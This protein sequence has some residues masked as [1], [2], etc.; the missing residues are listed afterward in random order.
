MRL[1]AVT[2][3][4][5][6]ALRPRMVGDDQVVVPL[7]PERA[8]LV[9]VEVA[10]LVLRRA[11]GEIMDQQKKVFSWK[12][13]GAGLRFFLPPLPDGDYVAEIRT[14]SVVL[15]ESGGTLKNVPLPDKAQ[16][17]FRRDS[18]AHKA[19]DLIVEH[20]IHARE[21]RKREFKYHFELHHRSV[22]MPVLVSSERDQNLDAEIMQ[23]RTVLSNNTVVKVTLDCW[24]SSDGEADYNK[25][26]SLKRCS[27][28]HQY[29]LN[30]AVEA[31]TALNVIEAAHGEDNPPEAEPA[32][33]TGKALQDIQARNRVVI[34]K[35]YTLD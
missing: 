30:K 15:T 21:P 5:D 4:S 34:L 23:L 25:E 19:D 11:S 28:V 6:F 1:V 29:V 10:L 8:H 12:T 26:V 14:T 3:A 22:D 32:G 24:A 33:V 9:S 27:W 20:N 35:V 7:P 13:R 17:S 2:E 31:D 18:L 16:I